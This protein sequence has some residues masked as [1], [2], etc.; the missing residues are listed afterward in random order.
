MNSLVVAA[1]I[2]VLFELVVLIAGSSVAYWVV[3]EAR[4]RERDRDAL[5]RDLLGPKRPPPPPSPEEL[6]RRRRIEEQNRRAFES[7]G[8]MQE[9]T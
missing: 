1:I 3:S 6:A 9:G 2:F 8:G 5:I 7:H 4:R